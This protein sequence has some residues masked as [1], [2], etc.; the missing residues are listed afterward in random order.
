MELIR[1]RTRPPRS[2]D[3]AAISAID[4]EGLATGNASFR[5]IPHDWDSFSASFLTGR[6]LALVAQDNSAIA[7]WAGISPG[8]AKEVYR[9][10]GEVSI[11]VSAKHQGKGV[12]GQ[13]LEALIQRAEQAGYWT[14]FAQ[15]FPEN[16]ASL[17]LHAAFG[18]QVLGTRK[19]L[20]KM[21][22][23][24]FKGKW[25]DVI[26]VERRSEIVF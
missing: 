22:Y 18:F 19:R 10:V 26:M 25:R 17:K 20:G 23:G 12:G 16:G 1:I 4:A 3:A 13:L 6:G 21:G 2:A 15:I 24:P 8:S 7:G 5:H 9:G 14:L 11:Y